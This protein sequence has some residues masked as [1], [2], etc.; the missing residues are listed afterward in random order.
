MDDL[1]HVPAADARP[2]KGGTCAH[3]RHKGMYVLSTDE[4]DETGAGSRSE[5]TAYWCLRTMKPLGPDG[6]PVNHDH[7]REGRSCCEP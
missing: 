3:L 6:Q 1:A 2:V 5:A 7:C 4:A